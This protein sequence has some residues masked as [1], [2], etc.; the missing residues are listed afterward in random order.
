MSDDD[1]RKKDC[2]LHQK[3]QDTACFT[4]NVLFAK[5]DIKQLILPVDNMFGGDDE[6]RAILEKKLDNYFERIPVP[7]SWLVLSLHFR[8][9]KSPT[10]NFKDCREIAAKFNIDGEEL[11]HALWFLHHGLGVILYYPKA[12]SLE[13]T[14]FCKIQAVFDS[15]ALL[16]KKTYTPEIVDIPSA[17]KFKKFGEFSLEN[18]PKS[19]PDSPIPR[20]MLV[21][22]LEHLNIITVIPTASC[23]QSQHA[24]TENLTYFMPCI[25]RSAT[26]RNMC[27][28]PP[29]EGDPSHLVLRYDCG[30]H[31]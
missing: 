15:V 17:D 5:P 18:V 19:I 3:I 1:F 29:K 25:L 27:V 31:Q 13:N 2:E 14:V 4:K 10:M 30:A 22:I 8:I 26:E 23:Q 12:S 7:A 24:V 9:Q 20:T 11:Q 6:I 28:P 16:I 21:K